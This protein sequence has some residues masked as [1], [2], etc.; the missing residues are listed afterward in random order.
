MLAGCACGSDGDGDSESSEPTEAAVEPKPAP[1]FDA[2]GFDLKSRTIPLDPPVEMLAA[3][4]PDPDAVSEP[5][6]KYV[7]YEWN[8]YDT[9]KLRVNLRL[10]NGQIK[11][12]SSA[13][14]AE[15]KTNESAGTAK[16]TKHA[17][18]AGGWEAMA[19]DPDPAE[20]VLHYIF[21]KELGAKVVQCEVEVRFYTAVQPATFNA[22]TDKARKMCTSLKEK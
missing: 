2:S 14:L 22:W 3:V 15:A 8:G 10:D 13:G 18:V 9:G 16:Y 4:L 11:P 19:L 17:E 21:H 7:F 12:T 6:G 1:K 20:G 5:A